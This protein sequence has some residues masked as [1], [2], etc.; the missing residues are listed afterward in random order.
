MMGELL[1]IGRN[2]VICV[3]ADVNILSHFLEIAA[4]GKNNCSCNILVNSILLRIM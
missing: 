1:Q 2:N 4:V 3:M